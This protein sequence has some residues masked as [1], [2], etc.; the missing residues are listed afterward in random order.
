VVRR[1]VAGLLAG[2]AGVA[3]ESAV[4]ATAGPGSCLG[5]RATI[6]GTAGSDRIPGTD[7]RDVIVARGGADRIR[8]GPGNDIICAGPGPDL[9]DGERGRDR[10]V[11]GEGDDAVL[12]SRGGD[13]LEAGRGEDEVLGDPEGHGSNDRLFGGPGSDSLGG[14][15]GDDVIR[16]GEG[17]DT[18]NF[19][20][21]HLRQ[22]SPL[23]VNLTTGVASGEGSDSLEDVENLWHNRFE[24]NCGP[25][26]F[27]GDESANVLEDGGSLP[28]KKIVLRGRGGDDV[29]VPNAGDD[30]ARGAGETTSSRSEEITMGSWG[31][32][33]ETTGSGVDPEWTR[34]PST[35]TMGTPPMP[36]CQPGHSSGLA[37]RKTL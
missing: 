5:R 31:S 33:M 2:L 8:S 35:T 16:G 25:V 1:A 18:A 10:V 21:V 29:L 13:R 30:I 26:T 34:R 23:V 20:A 17:T 14:W 6:T 36:T 24:C 9:A 28:G 7:A 12:G 27:I 15:R 37:W 19:G 22:P 32:R 3:A 11:G 4:Q